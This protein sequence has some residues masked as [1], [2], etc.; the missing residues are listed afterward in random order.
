MG[1]QEIAVDESR[2]T[3]E[4]GR[5]GQT[6]HSLASSS[7]SREQIDDEAVHIEEKK[8]TALMKKMQ[9]AMTPTLQRAFHQ[10]LLRD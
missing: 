6:H 8:T 1:D 5:L 4:K 9:E 7:D 2:R 3:L 10:Y